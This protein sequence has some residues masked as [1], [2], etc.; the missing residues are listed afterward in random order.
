[1]EKGIFLPGLES[2]QLRQ[3]PS[4][5]IS[6]V[7]KFSH[8]FSFLLWAEPLLDSFGI[9][10]CH[11]VN[12]GQDEVTHHYNDQLLKYPGQPVF[13]L[14]CAHSTSVVKLLPLGFQVFLEWLLQRWTYARDSTG[15]RVQYPKEKDTFG[16]KRRKNV[17]EKSTYH[18][19]SKSRDG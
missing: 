17:K 13:S 10:L 6:A 16:K 19:E 7:K 2:S 12:D 15:S 11:G 8:L 1:M 14:W 4:I 5:I 9:T 3:N 18:L